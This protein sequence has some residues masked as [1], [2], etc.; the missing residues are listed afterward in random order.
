M[1]QPRPNRQQGV[2]LLVC[3]IM[4][5]LMT[6]LVVTAFN[7]SKSNLKVVGNMQSHDE[8]VATAQS[9]IEEVLST[10]NFSD[11]PTAAFGA[12]NTKSY[13]VNGRNNAVT[14]TLNP[15]PCIK[16]Y[17][18]LTADPSDPTAQGCIAGAQQNF[19]VANAPTSGSSCADV[20]WEINA[21]ATDTVTEATTTVVQ[22]I[23]IRED[24]AAAATTA[25]YCP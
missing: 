10:T 17:K 2:V 6:L 3:L 8:V 21:V 22:G 23:R 15:P 25:N 18:M 20:I 19:G 9:A 16:S 4:L 1:K 24:S 14:V 5:V 12:G 11:S 7:L 13:S